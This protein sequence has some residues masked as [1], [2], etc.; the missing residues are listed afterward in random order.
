MYTRRTISKRVTYPK[1]NAPLRSDKLFS[2]KADEDHHKRI[3]IRESIENIGMVSQFPLDY[4]HLIYLGV[5][6]KLLL[7]FWLKG[8]KNIR[9][10]N[11]KI[12]LANQR[13][14]SLKNVT[15]AEFSRKPRSLSEVERFKAT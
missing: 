13:L 3:S 6:K 4:M 9:M 2:E 15:P 5:M 11:E 10:S 1:T 14:M 7:L 8:K 12:A